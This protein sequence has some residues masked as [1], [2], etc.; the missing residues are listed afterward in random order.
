MF[1]T[2]VVLFNQATWPKTQNLLYF[3]VDLF[4]RAHGFMASEQRRR[5]LNQ[6]EK[7][8]SVS[9]STNQ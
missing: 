2:A 1:I 8:I 4:F 7:E 6:Q 9:E 5:V 3:L